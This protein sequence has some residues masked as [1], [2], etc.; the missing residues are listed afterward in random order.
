MS[1][2]IPKASLEASLN[3]LFEVP[4][5]HG[6]E[7]SEYVKIER[8]K[9]TIAKMSLSS[10]MSGNVYLS[11]EPGCP[12]K[13]PVYIDRRMLEPFI[14]AGKDLSPGFYELKKD[15][16]RITLRHGYRHGNYTSNKKAHGYAKLP[17][18]DS[19][20][21]S[22][23]EDL[24]A[25]LECAR[26]V[27]VDDPVA[28]HLS[29]VF[30]YIDGDKL[31]ALSANAHVFFQGYIT[32]EKGFNLK[33][34]AL[35]LP[36]IDA[37]KVENEVELLYSEKVAVLKFSCGTLWHPVKSE[38]RKK[39][40]RKD[41]EKMIKAGLEGETILQIDAD[42][43]YDSAERASNYMASV[44]SEDPVLAIEV[45]K[46]D[47]DVKMLCK[48]VGADFCEKIKLSKASKGDVKIEWPLKAIIPI[49]DYSRKAGIA[50]VSKDEK[51]RTCFSAGNI[52]M[53]I[54]RREK[55]EKKHS[56]KKKEKK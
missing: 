46:G 11:A 26:S 23:S 21:H 7:S 15:G 45:K 13:D 22:L 28:P 39:F 51:G 56:K 38:A 33:S 40:P 6:V 20:A 47:T 4:T 53:L 2:K 44:M 35:P 25:M 27:A 31:R 42:P 17:K 29:C 32:L 1:W 8:H 49:L 41:I 9:D 36:L 18:I 48:A 14:T 55:K 52:A 10:D 19:K 16:G 30:V 50:K 54:A 43:L 34:A 12:L 24:I 37:A 3:I 5:R